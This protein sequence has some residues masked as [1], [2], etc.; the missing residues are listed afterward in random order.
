VQDSLDCCHRQWRHGTSIVDKA[1]NKHDSRFAA[2][3]VR[4][5][6]GLL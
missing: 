4:D 6:F 3:A 5:D 1:S 2:E